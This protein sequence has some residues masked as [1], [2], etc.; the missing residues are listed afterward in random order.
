MVVMVGAVGTLD[1]ASDG[2]AY[3]ATRA[4]ASVGVSRRPAIMRV[5]RL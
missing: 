4:A 2:N 1:A 5:K 3:C